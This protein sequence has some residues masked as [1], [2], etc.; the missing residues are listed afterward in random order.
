MLRLLLR[1]PLLWPLRRH[2]RQNRDANQRQNRL[3]ML[4][5]RTLW[6]VRYR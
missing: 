4:N 5:R 1:L 2:P 6:I 3:L